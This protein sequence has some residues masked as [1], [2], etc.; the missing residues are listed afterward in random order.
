VEQ[1]LDRG[2]QLNPRADLQPIGELAG[3]PMKVLARPSQRGLA[4]ALQLG[5]R[6]REGRIPSDMGEHHWRSELL[7]QLADVVHGRPFRLFVNSHQ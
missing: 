4:V 6:A 7:G 1:R 2:S 3:N 5:R